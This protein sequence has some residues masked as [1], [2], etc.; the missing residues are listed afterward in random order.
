MNGFTAVIIDENNTIISTPQKV[1]LCISSSQVTSGYLSE[2]DK[3]K[4]NFISLIVNEKKQQFYK[5]GDICYFEKNLLMYL[6]R[7]DQQVKI[8]G[9]RVELSEIE[10]HAREA[11]KGKNTVA[12]TYTHITQ[13]KEIALFIE[14]E[15]VDEIALKHYLKTKLPSYMIPSK[16]LLQKTFPLNSNGKIDRKTLALELT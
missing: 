3:N 12:V 7:I 1:E 10:F 5:T 6:G 16:Y 2:A 8:Q 15:N 11:L 9:Y 4:T 13:T 14:D